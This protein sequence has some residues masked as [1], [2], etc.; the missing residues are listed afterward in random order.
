MSR[1][2]NYELKLNKDGLSF[3][4][5]LNKSFGAQISF[6]QT[7]T[8]E[9]GTVHEV[10]TLKAVTVDDAK[11]TEVSH[12]KRI[13]PWNVDTSY[14]YIDEETGE[15]KLLPLD[16]KAKCKMF[17]KSDSL[18]G[19]GFLD[20]KKIPPK[21]FSGDHYYLCP[22]AD[23]KTKTIP[24]SHQQGYS[25]LHAALSDGL[26]MFLCKFISGDREK[27]GAIYV[28]DGSL[29]L[30]ILIHNNYQREPTPFPILD[31]PNVKEYASKL[32][33]KLPLEYNPEELCDRYEQSLCEYIEELKATHT[34]APVPSTKLKLKPKF[35]F[36]AANDFLSQLDDL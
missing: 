23:S 18:T 20:S 25:L 31:I 10:R 16:D 9:D 12:I 13:V 5:C 6:R 1:Q 2:T 8:D 11:P 19:M 36:K 29:M 35:Q 28:A 26:H 32:V 15:Q 24:V 4:V 34:H 33:A 27:F 30:S 22:K 7:F 21:M 17:Q 3:P 14:P